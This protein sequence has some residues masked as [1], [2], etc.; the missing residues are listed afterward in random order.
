MKSD[1]LWFGFLD[2]GPKSSPVIRS[3]LLDTKNPD[4]V[5]LFNLQRNDILVYHRSIVEPKLRELGVG[6]METIRELKQA[7]K[8][9]MTEFKSREKE[10]PPLLKK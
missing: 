6:D 1:S 3:G 4:T 8:K 7:F 2:A 5:F 10:S 9:A